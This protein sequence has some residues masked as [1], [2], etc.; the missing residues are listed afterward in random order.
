MTLESGGESMYFVAAAWVE[1]VAD[2]EM[3][4]ATASDVMV[5]VF[6]M[7]LFIEQFVE[8]F[9]FGVYLIWQIRQLQNAP[10]FVTRCY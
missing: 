6:I 3:R 8:I 7:N 5:L 10:P 9:M 4:T 2:P 1:R